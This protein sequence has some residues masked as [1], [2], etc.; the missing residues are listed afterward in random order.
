MLNRV[1]QAHPACALRID[2]TLPEVAI[3]ADRERV[4]RILE[5]SAG[6]LLA[7]PSHNTTLGMGLST[8]GS[9]DA[10]W[11]R[12]GLWAG[13]DAMANEPSAGLMMDGKP[14]AIA[15]CGAALGFFLAQRLAKLERGALSTTVTSSGRVALQ[16]SLPV[17]PVK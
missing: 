12:L 6:L 3:L 10:K 9:T 8:D 13:P 17:R 14:G 5:L 1:A 7:H 4:A 2:Q 15:E 16:L 11:A